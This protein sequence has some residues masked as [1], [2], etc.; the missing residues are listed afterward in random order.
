MSADRPHAEPRP[1]AGGGPA[2]AGRVFA[3]TR[4][5][6][7]ADSLCARIE[8]EGGQA[9]RFPLLAIDP[10]AST[11]ELD[12]VL[13]R[14]ETFDLAFFV[15]P[16]AIAHA[17]GYLLPRCTWPPGLAVATVGKGSERVLRSHGFATVIAPAEGFDSEAV[18]ALDEFSAAAIAGRRVLIFRGDGGRNLLA[19]TLRARGA[20]VEFVCCYR[21]S[22]PPL[23]PA[24]LLQAHA[25]QALD[26][27]L[28]TSTEGVGNL[29]SIIGTAGV[30]ALRELAVFVSHPRIGAAARAAGFEHLVLTEAGDD[31]LMQALR[32]HFG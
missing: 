6:A 30:E 29:L 10:P 11:A 26:G 28:L 17:M 15:S 4:P 9:L 18:L 32:Q 5:Q 8:A 14:L 3:V 21:R 25:R 1:P 20:E 7:Q 24:L 22:C 19:D 31:G 16:N 27:L 12:D 2:L 23:D 13:P